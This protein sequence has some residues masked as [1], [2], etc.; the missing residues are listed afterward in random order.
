MVSYLGY[1]FAVVALVILTGALGFHAVEVGRNPSI[2]GLGDSLWWALVT[3]TTIGYGDIVPATTAGR[4]FGG[5][6]M[7]TGIG[8]L[9]IWTAAIAAYLIKFDQLDAIRIRGLRDHVVICGL[10]NAGALLAQAFRAEGY[11]VLVIEKEQANPH[12]RACRD[13]G[14]AVLVA[15]AARPETLRRAR[16]DRAKH[17]V[18]V[19]GTDANNVEITAQARTV[20]RQ[21]ARGLSCST[22]IVDPELWYALQS[23]EIGARDAFRLTFFNFS[24]LGARALLSNHSP[25]HGTTA[26]VRAPHVLVVGA[27]PLSQHL[28]RH[29]VRQ[30]QDIAGEPRPPLRVTLID[31]D[32]GAVHEHLH[33]RH[34]ELEA[35]A[36][37]TSLSVDLRS[38]RFQRASFLFDERGHCDV[39]HAYVCIDDEGLALSTALLLLNH[40]FRFDVP[41]VVRMNRQHGLAALLQVVAARGDR[42]LEQLH[43]FSLLEEVCQPELLLRGTN[44]VLARALHQYYVSKVGQQ[45][46]QHPSAVP[47][48]DLPLEMKESNRA[49]ADHIATKLEAV[50]C[51]LVPLTALEAD[52]FT[53]TAP[54]VE[55]LAT[56]EHER[57]V[58]ERRA[59]GWALGARDLER[60][61]N[62]NLIAWED[63]DEATREMNRNSVRQLPAFLNRAGFTVHRYRS[64]ER[65]ARAFREPMMR[66]T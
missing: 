46:S 8:V 53:F 3:A 48:S 42:A 51:H 52:S 54:E 4:V 5:F 9:G 13:L 1:G 40:L 16:L 65:A 58:A 22:Q 18:V 10:G 36:A 49:Q 23:W 30:W 41:V 55:R 66:Q 47:W 43:V 24:E 21:R 57:W 50:G 44:E 33:H 11:R 39:S 60:K 6:V 27:G 26:A 25:F 29:M 63:L 2:N 62:P 12:V 34:P 56:M 14:A 17:L 59:L 19:C 64:D 15:D 7:F 37:I 31:K 38:T 35:L 45:R 20:Q 28:I 61:T 32:T